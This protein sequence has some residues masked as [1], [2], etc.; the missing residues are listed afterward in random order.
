MGFAKQLFTSQFTRKSKKNI[1]KSWSCWQEIFRKSSFKIFYISK[2]SANFERFVDKNV[3]SPTPSPVATSLNH[4]VIWFQL[5]YF[6]VFSVEQVFWT[7]LICGTLFPLVDRKGV[8][9]HMHKGHLLCSTCEQYWKLRRNILFNICFKRSNSE[10][11]E[12]QE[13]DHGSLSVS[14]S[15]SFFEESFSNSSLLSLLPSSGFSFLVR[16][17]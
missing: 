7:G 17:F 3:W 4:D 10:S 1:Y 13:P 2:K 11:Q 9:R 8:H 14:V 12:E 5:A 15:N 6:M 16:S